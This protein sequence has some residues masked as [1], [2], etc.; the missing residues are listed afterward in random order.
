VTWVAAILKFIS[1]IVDL[2][3]NER[4]MDAGKQEEQNNVHKANTEARKKAKQI[5]ADINVLPSD[6]V[7]AKLSKYKRKK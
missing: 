3:R 6:I 1:A 5:A 7:S 4:L 2:Y